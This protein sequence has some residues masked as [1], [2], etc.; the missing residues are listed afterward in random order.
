M[1]KVQV[2]RTFSL[3]LSSVKRY[4]YKVQRGESLAPSPAGWDGWLPG[5]VGAHS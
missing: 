3:S 4:V 5:P 2:A 1:S